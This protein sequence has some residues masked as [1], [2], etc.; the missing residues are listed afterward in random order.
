MRLLQIARDLL[1]AL[2]GTG[3]VEMQEKVIEIQSGIL[4]MQ[5]QVMELQRE[6]Q[7]LREQLATAASLTYRDNSYWRDNHPDPGP[8]CPRCWDL[9]KKLIHLAPTFDPRVMACPRCKNPVE[10]RPTEKT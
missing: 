10:S 6:N 3:T 7:I 2:K 9:E 5:E 8:F 4:E 1:K